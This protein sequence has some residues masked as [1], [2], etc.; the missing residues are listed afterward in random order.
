MTDNQSAA[1]TI[2]GIALLERAINYTLGSL[3]MVTP[4]A[5]S[6]PTPCPRWDLGD[7]LE[8]MNDSLAALTEAVDFGDVAL[9]PP[10]GDLDGSVDPV[11]RLRDRACRLLGAWAAAGDRAAV[12]VGGCPVTTGIVAG[13]GAIEV[14]VHGWDVAR[15]CGRER[16]VPA[17]LA[18]ELL[19][20]APL[21]V[22]GDERPGRFAPAVPVPA[23]AAPG[24][25]LL[26]FL[27]RR[28]G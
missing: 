4:V 14:A 9:T 20:L 24:D 12:S 22:T 28:P 15:A 8:H 25:R 3:L 7:L 1:A 5:L 21:L 10:V 13:A 23:R 11:R 17:S 26:A 2:G 27:G 16:P 18:E 6:R 19:D